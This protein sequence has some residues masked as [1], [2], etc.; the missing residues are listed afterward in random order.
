MNIYDGVLKSRLA[1]RHGGREISLN[2]IDHITNT[3]SYTVNGDNSSIHRVAL[4]NLG[5]TRSGSNYLIRSNPE[6][7]RHIE[8]SQLSILG[9][10]LNLGK[11]KNGGK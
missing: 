8:E 9:D 4:N 10:L 1:Q 3:V 6:R 11:N 5:F 7:V 2:S